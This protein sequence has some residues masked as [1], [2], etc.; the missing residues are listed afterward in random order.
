MVVTAVAVLN[1]IRT[2]G[3]Q[4]RLQSLEYYRGYVKD[5]EILAQAHYIQTIIWANPEQIQHLV[6]HLSVL[7]SDTDP[8]CEAVGMV[9][10]HRCHI[11]RL[12]PGAKYEEH[13]LHILNRSGYG[14][15]FVE[16]SI[17]S[18]HYTG[19]RADSHRVGGNIPG[20]H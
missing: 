2:L 6:K 4:N 5:K 15:P 13:F 19:R 16:V 3:S 9:K 10:Y 11:D 17:K 20:N 14:D 12:G 7:G 1:H 18:F 8:A